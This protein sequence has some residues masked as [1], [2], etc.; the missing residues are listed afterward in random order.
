MKNQD[1]AAKKKRVLSFVKKHRL[2]DAF[3]ALRNF[4]E[5]LMSWEV[6]DEINRVEQSY[7]YMLDYAMKGAED[8]LRNSIY[9]EIVE[10]IVVLTDRLARYAGATDTP[11]LYY[12]TVRY[13]E[14]AGESMTLPAMVDDYRKLS[15]R[16]SLLNMVAAGDSAG[17][18]ADTRLV[19]EALERRIFNKL[20]ITFPLSTGDVDAVAAQISSESVPPYFKQ[21]LV[22]ALLLGCMEYYDERRLLL[23]MDAY[24]CD[25]TTISSVSLIAML[26]V[27]FTFRDR[28]LSR[29]VRNRLAALTERKNW[30]EDLCMAFMELVRARD[31][32]RITRKMQDEVVPQM[33]KLRPDIYKKINDSKELVDISDIEENPE[34][35]ELLEKSGIADRMKELTEIQQE[36][37]DV[38]MATFAHLKSFPFFSDIANWFMP[39]HQDHSVVISAGDKMMPVCEIIAASPFFCNGDKY[40][41]VLSMQSV[42]DAQR[43]MM[44]SQLNAQNVNMA[45][46]Q[47]ASLQLGSS[48]RKTVMNKYVQDLYRFF[49]LFRRKCEFRDPFETE[50]NLVA[51]PALASEFRDADMLQVIAEFYFRHHYYSDALE[52]FKAIEELS[53]PSVSLFQKMGYCYQKLNDLDNALKYYEQAELLNADSVWTLRKIAQCYRLQNLPGKALEYLRRIDSLQPDNVS[54]QLSLGHCLMELGRYDEASRYYFKAEFIDGR[55]TRAWRPLAWCLFMLKDFDRSRCYFD[56]LLADAPQHGDYLNLGHL[57]LAC[58]DMQQALNHYRT[59]MAMSHSTIDEF[60]DNLYRDSEYLRQVGIDTSVLPLI[61][62]TLIYSSGD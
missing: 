45:E 1:I 42:P 32:E 51:V 24:D 25:D 18:H 6:T 61:V 33:M 60:I 13:E 41:F 48:R 58:K 26:L 57:S 49:R 3:K 27:M 59:S 40:S 20:W 55:S 19:R 47:N 5:T 10:S 36:G 50:L 43:N 39:F 53:C 16:L 11:T 38:F 4:S 54:V 22:S 17:E 35:Q 31:T 56:R 44:L 23:L 8:P 29:R 15:E 2:R 9:D 21:L 37:G 34:W 7:R 28:T 30:H 62:D 52:L 14:R 12:N 46:L